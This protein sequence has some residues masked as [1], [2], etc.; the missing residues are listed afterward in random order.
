MARKPA[1]KLADDS[2]PSIAPE[3]ELTV[4]Q[5]KLAKA[6]HALQ[7]VSEMPISSGARGLQ[8]CVHIATNT[9]AELNK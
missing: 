6:K 4:L 1:E 9:L 2:A 3:S 7:C 8:G 5:E